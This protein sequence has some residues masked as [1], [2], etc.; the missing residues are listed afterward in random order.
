MIK[1]IPL[2]LDF[3]IVA[4]ENLTQAF[5]LLFKVYVDYLDYDEAIKEEVTIDNL[6]AHHNGTIRTSLILLHQAIEGL[7]KATI[8][9]TSPLLLIDK[10]RKDWPTVK[11]ID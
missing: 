10:P 1:N 7:M 11:K 5:N 3:E 9:E 4:K 8:C 6:W 2:K